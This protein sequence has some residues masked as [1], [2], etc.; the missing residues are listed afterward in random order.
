VAPHRRQPHSNPCGLIYVSTLRRTTRPKPTRHTA[1]A[2]RVVD[3]A[4]SYWSKHIGSANVIGKW[5]TRLGAG[6]RLYCKV[7][8]ENRM[9]D[10][11]SMYRTCLVYQRCE[12]SYK[13]RDIDLQ[14]DWSDD[15]IS[16]RRQRS[17]SKGAALVTG[18]H[19][20]DHKWKLS[21]HFCATF[22]GSPKR[23]QLHRALQRDFC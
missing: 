21:H 14:R 4:T 13:H 2:W 23:R 5:N 7:A 12:T 18:W 3:K 8:S 11:T 6:P 9:R 15:S 22:R 20:S 16:I 17:G 19:R 1:C 10:S